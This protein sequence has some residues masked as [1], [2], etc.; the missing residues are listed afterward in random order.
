MIRLAIVLAATALPLPALAQAQTEE[1]PPVE[2]ETPPAAPPEEDENIVVR[3]K[4]I[5]ERRVETGSIVPRR[6]CRT[7]EQVAAEQER[8]QRVLEQM[9]DDQNTE[10]F[11]RESQRQGT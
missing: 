7:P 9:R 8:S 2:A 3:G 11:T 6:I 5:C 1:T 10:R 4:K